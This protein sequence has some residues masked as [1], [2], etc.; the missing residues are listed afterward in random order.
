MWPELMRAGRQGAL[1]VATAVIATAASLCL[2]ACSLAG[3]SIH[4]APASVAGHDDR[5]NVVLIQADDQTSGQFNRHVMPRTFRRLVDHGTRF[6]DYIATTAECCPSRA[7]L[8]TGQYAHNDGVTSNQV[9]YTGLVDKDSLLPVWLRQ[10]GYRTMEVGAKYVNG[11][12]R[13]SDR[14]TDVAPGWSNWF[15]V[16]SHTQYYDY[17]LSSGGQ[18]RSRGHRPRDYITRVLANKAT[19]LIGR[20]A[21][22][23]KP[24]YLQL[25]ERA[26]HVSLSED[27]HGNCD[28]RP[29][30][31]PRDEGAFAK[32][33]LPDPPSFNEQDMTD[34]PAFLRATPS[35]SAGDQARLTA[36]WRCS[37]ETLQGVDRTVEQVYKAVA[38]S[39]ELDRTVFIYI[40]DN[41]LFYGEHRIHE[42][43]VFPYES[44]SRLPLVMRVPKRYRGDTERLRGTN[45][46]VGNIDLAPTILGLTHAKPCVDGR[47]RTMD[48]RSLM[49]LLER[50]GQ[51]PR[52]RA[53]LNEYRIPDVPRYSTC[54]FAAV[55]TR[56]EIYVEHHRVVDPDTGECK[57]TR[58]RERYELAGDP[59]EMNNLCYGGAADSCPRDAMQAGLQRRL[60]RLR[61]C[62]GIQGRDHRVDG[63][64]YCE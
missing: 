3:K 39:G 22:S 53:L 18:H 49:P 15:Q 30:P 51:W 12:K 31:D 55:R 24:F 25:D 6:R 2:G 1:T 40:S 19:R 20:R 58:Q 47:C 42:G 63:R 16:L 29:I 45:R 61:R 21:L 13:Y 34:K 28:G 27:P 35:L 46:L 7:S 14:A 41:G 56:R 50:S 44:A 52:N 38:E 59:W 37:L 9:G 4:A 8:L 26:P 57:P 36:K 43:K 48:G 32:A 64:P 5:P 17:R 11:Y 54:E 60:E 10:G 33:S 23:P 62:A